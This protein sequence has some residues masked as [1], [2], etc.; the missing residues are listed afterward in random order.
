M[1]KV[2]IKQ[3]NIETSE[4]VKK[5]SIYYGDIQQHSCDLVCIPIYEDT[6]TKGDIYTLL[7]GIGMLPELSRPLL[8]GPSAFWTEVMMKNNIH[9]VTV[10]MN[11][12]D[13]DLLSP[14]ELEQSLKLTF[15]SLMTYQLERAAFRSVAMP[16]YFRKVVDDVQYKNY[17]HTYLYEASQFLRTTATADCVEIYLWNQ[18]DVDGWLNVLD[19][20]LRLPRDRTSNNPLKQLVAELITVL[21]HPVIRHSQPNWLLQK[22]RQQ[23]NNKQIDYENFSKSGEALVRNTLNSFCLKRDLPLSIQSAKIFEKINMLQSQRI[24]IEW[25][26]TYMRSIQIF[27]HYAKENAISEEEGY[28]YLLRITQILHHLTKMIQ[29]VQ[30]E[31]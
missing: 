21:N 30:H 8:Y 16:V 2:L 28:L 4:K 14:K 1:E 17:I 31:Q 22:V 11:R 12:N 19:V 29:G 9:Y 27:K 5:L 10:H 23:L 7:K 25:L 26:A 20:E 3:F 13:K 15:T 18:E 24:V 6:E